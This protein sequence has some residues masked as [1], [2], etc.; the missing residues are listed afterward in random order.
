MSAWERLTG[1][2]SQQSANRR[3]PLL[4]HLGT[5]G[6]MSIRPS[7]AAVVAALLLL[8]AV[9]FGTARAAPGDPPPPSRPSPCSTV[10]AGDY[11]GDGLS[12]YRE[13]QLGTNPFRSDTDR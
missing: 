10:L 3:R 6:K 2:A 13:C 12:N 1:L 9:G 11:D 8:D 7:A 4:G 5:G